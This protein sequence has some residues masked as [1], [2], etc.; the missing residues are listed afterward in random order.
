TEDIEAAAAVL[1][2]KRV[3]EGVT[4]KVVPAT[5]KVFQDLLEKGLLEDLF[6]S[7]AIVSNPGCG[8]C[9]EGHIGLTGEGEV[10]VSTGNRNFPGKQGRGKTYLASPA[11]VAAS[12]VAGEILSPEDL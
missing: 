8:G 3:K 11:V 1:R 7:G 12:C 4:L 9:A 5:R 10:Q 2:G 6:R